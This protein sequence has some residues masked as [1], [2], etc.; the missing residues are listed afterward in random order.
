MRSFF[1]INRISELIFNRLFL[2]NV[3]RYAVIAKFLMFF[4]LFDDCSCF[5]TKS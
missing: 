5:F 1:N 4:E 3:V 2:Q